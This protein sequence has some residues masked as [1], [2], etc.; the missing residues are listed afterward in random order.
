MA[1]DPETEFIAHRTA[2]DRIAQEAGSQDPDVA[3][4]V[5]GHLDRAEREL[6]AIQDALADLSVETVQTAQGTPSE[7]SGE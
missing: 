3:E 7:G 2:I 1:D 5:S 6:D 4:A